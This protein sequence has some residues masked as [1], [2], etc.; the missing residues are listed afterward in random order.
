VG[1]SK[2]AYKKEGEK[3]EKVFEGNKLAEVASASRSLYLFGWA[4][5]LRGIL[6]YGPESRLGL[7]ASLP[8]RLL[9][10]SAFG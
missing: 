5:Y 3:E 7:W 6:L 10:C 4:S 2:V 9:A 8:G 1:N